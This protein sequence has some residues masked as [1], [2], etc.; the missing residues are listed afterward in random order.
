MK[1]KNF[2]AIVL[3]SFCIGFVCGAVYS[4]L[5]LDPAVKTENRQAQKTEKKNH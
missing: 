5:K 2:V 4:S 1:N 3:V